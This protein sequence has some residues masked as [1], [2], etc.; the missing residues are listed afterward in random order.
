MGD[1]MTDANP[2]LRRR[3]L[4]VKLR[5]LRL[6]AS[7]TVEDV[8]FRLLCS[9]SKISR[10]ETGQRAVS[11]RDVRDLC[12]IYGVHDPAEQEH[13][14]SLARAANQRGWWQEYDDLGDVR[15]Y[16]YIGLEDQAAKI[17]IFHS[18]SVPALLQTEEY[19]RT[20][21][22]GM[23]SPINDNALNERIEARL[24]RQ[25]RLT[26]PRPPRLNVFIDEAA[27]RRCVG[28]AAI[29]SAQAARILELTELPNVTVRVVS[30]DAGAHPAMDSMFSFLEF[31][32]P[33]VPGIVYVEGLAGNIYI[34]RETDLERYRQTLERLAS[35]ALDSE[36]SADFIK[37]MSE[38]FAA[39]VDGAHACGH[40]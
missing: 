40:L 9:Q 17:S 33:S 24:V 14:M 32:N 7:L 37:K 29:M 31:N 26:A 11:L 6:Q 28:N 13:L 1:P 10:L 8:A 19:A 25:K 38:T 35:A 39:R 2:T 15:H 27:L 4:G 5:G 34:E 18:S 30:Y 20:L 36:A 3:E 21:I 23:L 16:T 12:G 22:R